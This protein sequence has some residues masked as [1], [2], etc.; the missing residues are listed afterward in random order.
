MKKS[1]LLGGLLALT[2]AAVAS[3]APLFPETS[4]EHWAATAMQKL[5]AAG[6]IEG[7]PQGGLRG[8]RERVWAVWP[9]AC[10]SEIG[11]GLRDRCR[12]G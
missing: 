6:L 11:V 2:F 4:D 12:A 5:R 3:A 9:R 1:T 10:E 7:Y 8:E